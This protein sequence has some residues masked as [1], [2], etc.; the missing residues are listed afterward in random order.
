[1]P[2]VFE[3]NKFVVSIFNFQYNVVSLHPETDSEPAC[4][5]HKRE[6]KVRA[7]QG[8]P[9]P[10]GKWSARVSKCRRK[11]PPPSRGKGEKVRQ[12]LTRSAVMSMLCT[13]GV[14]SSCKPATKR[15]GG[16]LELEGRTIEDSG[17]TVRR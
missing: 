5:C 2:F 3:D 6:R 7:T 9:L 10:N 11:E 1:M 8:I 17:D 15:E 12:E 4:R 14:E 16:P 13:P